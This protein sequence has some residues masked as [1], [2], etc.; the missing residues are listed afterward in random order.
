MRLTKIINGSAVPIFRLDRLINKIFWHPREIPTL[1]D[2][3][4]SDE[5]K[6]KLK[7]LRNKS[8]ERH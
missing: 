3:I 2:R 8:F 6:E 7:W 1:I 5:Q 4:K